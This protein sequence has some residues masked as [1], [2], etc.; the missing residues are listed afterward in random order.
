[1][2][3]KFSEIIQSGTPTLVDFYADWCGPCKMMAPI[4][5]EVKSKIGNKA[6]IIKIDTDKN[7]QVLNT[8]QIRGIPTLILFMNGEIKWRQSGV[9]SANVIE[10]VINQYSS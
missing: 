5:E 8:Y 1:M 3:K 10:N 2:T 4:L 9:V 7:P 6:M